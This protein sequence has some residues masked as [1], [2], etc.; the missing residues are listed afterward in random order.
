MP[1]AY[2]QAVAAPRLLSVNVTADLHQG[3]AWTGSQKRSGIDK[4][5][6]DGPR[7]LAGDAVEGDA[8]INTVH[9]G[10]PWQAVYAYAREDADWWERHL[11]IPI[12]NGRFGENLT[13]AGLD[14]SGALIG[15]RW[16]IGE[17]VVQ[18][19]LPRIPCRVFARFWGRPD[20][21]ATFTTARRPGAYLRIVEPG[22]VCAGDAV[23]V[24]D[25]PGVAASIAQA[26][27]C[28]TGD[29]TDLDLLRQTADLAPS[30]R[31]WL[32]RIAAD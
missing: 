14:I 31:D 13:T 25:R 10:G 29:R 22:R 4:R 21:I 5:P 16:Q 6:V 27:A 11:Q 30:W 12:A 32:A 2:A 26:F 19:T 1:T 20:L 24:I 28:K 18:V 23:E 15:E 7:M 3:A 8:V 17:A 9:H